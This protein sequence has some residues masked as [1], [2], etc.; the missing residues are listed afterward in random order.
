ME[1]AGPYRQ[2]AISSLVG[3]DNKARRRCQGCI[4]AVL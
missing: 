2:R 4:A 3:T 1:L